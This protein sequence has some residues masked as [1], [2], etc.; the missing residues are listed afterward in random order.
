MFRG[1]RPAPPPTGPQDLVAVPRS[2]LV[3]RRNVLRAVALLTG[4]VAWGIAVRF[5]DSL[6]V[7][8]GLLSFALKAGVGFG[9]VLA[10][11]IAIAFR[12]HEIERV[13]IAVGLAIAGAAFGLAIGPTVPP[14]ITVSGSFT[15]VPATPAGL[16][17]SRDELECEWAN[18]RTKVGEVRTPPLAGFTTPYRLTVDFLRDTITLANGAGSSLVAIGA[19]AFVPPPDAPPLGQGD[20]SGILDLDLLQVGY[21]L[22]ADDPNEVIGRFT[23]ECP[24]PPPG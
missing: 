16:P 3:T 8:S 11:A 18:G 13:A 1:R 20:S 21:D 9:F 5:T 23:W 4:G 12:G 7:D 10:A 22:T 2:P 19:D 14:A 24:T 6:P 17:E 15:F